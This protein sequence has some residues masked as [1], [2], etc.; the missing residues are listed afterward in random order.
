MKMILNALKSLIYG[1]LFFCFWIWIDL[2]IKNIDKSFGWSLPAG[3][4][5]PGIILIIIGFPIAIGTALS[6]VLY[7]QGTPAP[8][9]APK[10]FVV[11]GPYKYVRNPMYIGGFFLFAGFALINYYSPSVHYLL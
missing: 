2:L 6:F 3:V 11:V 10:E 8:F 4:Y 9:D 5:F 7:G 1:T